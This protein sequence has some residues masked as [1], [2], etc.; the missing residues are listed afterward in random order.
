[1]ANRPFLTVV[2]RCFKRPFLLREN[3]RSLKSQ[4]DPDYEQIF[5]IDRVGRGLAQADR[6]LSKYKDLNIGR[7]VMVL[8]DD[9]KI[10]TPNFISTIKT[11]AEKGN[12]DVMIWRGEFGKADHALPLKNEFWGKKIIRSKIGSF[13]YG[14]KREL[15]NEHIHICK[16]GIMGDF[17]FLDAVLCHNPPP[18][19][20]WI[21]KVFV[22]IQVKSK[23]KP[24]AKIRE[25]GGRKIISRRNRINPNRF[26]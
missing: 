10:T 25:V 17:D 16:T 9:D 5:I 24:V 12:P 7:Y 6:A 4:T 14:I 18:N 23:G 15:Y 20:I 11:Y 19:V 8:D 26:R 21:D 2:T 13:N 22:A 3:V 1:M